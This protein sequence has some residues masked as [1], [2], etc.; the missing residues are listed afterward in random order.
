MDKGSILSEKALVGN[1]FY[2]RMNKVQL[3]EWILGFW[4]PLIGYSPR[5]S[6]LSNH[7]VVFHFF[8]ESNLLR[9]LGSPWIIGRG[10]LMLR[11]WFPSF[12]HLTK[13]FSKRS[14][15]MLLPNFPIEFWSVRIFEAVAN[16][17][18]KFVFFDELS[19][20][21]SNKRLAWVLVELDLT[22]GLDDVI[23]ISIEDS[24]IR[25]LVDFWR[26]PFRCH[27]CWQ[28]GHLKAMCPGS[29]EHSLDT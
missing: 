12:N 8:A 28:T 1:F 29:R 6:L 25:Q 15:W 16:S 7:W 10:I 21:W 17:V 20:R 4:K 9:I 5:F 3:I 18:G 23:D 24:H 26:E 11:R 27:S 13:I 14:F 2:T 22:R 19:L